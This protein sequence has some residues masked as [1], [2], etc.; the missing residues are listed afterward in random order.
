VTVSV[1]SGNTIT[2]SNLIRPGRLLATLLPFGGIGLIFAGRRRRW[3]L[4]L[5]LVVCLALGMVSCGGGG[6]SSSS[7]QTPQV[8]VTATTSSGT[9]QC[10]VALTMQ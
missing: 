4:M 2:I 1:P 9:A 10:V 7:S 8:K 5:G 6:G 3:L